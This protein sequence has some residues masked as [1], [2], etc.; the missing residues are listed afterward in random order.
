MDLQRRFITSRRFAYLRGLQDQAVNPGPTI[1]LR[2]IR[3]F[4]DPRDKKNKKNEKNEK[5]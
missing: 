5:K 3:V 4:S 1:H 2:Q